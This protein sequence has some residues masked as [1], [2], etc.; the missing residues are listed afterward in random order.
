M[1]SRIPRG[2]PG[3]VPARAPKPPADRD[4]PITVSQAGLLANLQGA[5]SAAQDRVNA[6]VS[7]ILGGHDIERAQVVGV[8]GT[9][10]KPT[11]VVRVAPA[12][13]AD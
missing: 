5:V 2:A 9:A 3:T 13:Q 8:A 6:A 1:R 4:L 10:E 11:L 7:A 12:S